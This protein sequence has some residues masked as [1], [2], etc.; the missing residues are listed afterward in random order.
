MS[1]EWQRFTYVPRTM[2]TFGRRQPF[3]IYDS[4][5]GK[6]NQKKLLFYTLTLVISEERQG[7]EVMMH[8]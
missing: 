4:K 6:N 7:R 5:S 8:R 1:A 2:Q 3:G